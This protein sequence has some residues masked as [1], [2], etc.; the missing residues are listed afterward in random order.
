MYFLETVNNNVWISP[1]LVAA[2]IGFGGWLFKGL[3]EKYV[4]A[5]ETRLEHG[6]E[7]VEE[8]KRNYNQKFRE[9]HE[10]IDRTK[11]VIIDR[12][13]RMNQ[14]QM[15]WRMQSSKDTASIQ[16]DIKHLADTIN[17]NNDGRNTRG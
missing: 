4:K 8:V 9:V 16:S 1:A 14:E 13:D 7:E 2:A 6:E 5:I 10:K 15:N 3:A 17:R 11:E 12:I